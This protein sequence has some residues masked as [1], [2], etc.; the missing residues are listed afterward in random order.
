[1]SE[2]AAMS[3]AERRRQRILNNT[4]E[5]MKKI[6]GGQ[7]YHEEHLKLSSSAT[8]NSETSQLDPVTVTNPFSTN[9]QAR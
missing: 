3:R 4:D 7:N 8:M 5:R 1:M 2:T 9:A 6:F